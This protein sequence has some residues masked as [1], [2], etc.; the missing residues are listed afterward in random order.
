[1]NESHERVDAITKHNYYANGIENFK[2]KTKQQLRL[3]ILDKATSSV[4]D[5]RSIS[6]RL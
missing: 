3:F 2:I 5:V 6:F 4:S 1:M